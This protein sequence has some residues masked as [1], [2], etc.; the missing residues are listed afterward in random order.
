MSIKPIDYTSLIPKAQEVSRL[1]QIENNKP[2]N[3]IQHGNIQLQKEIEHNINK[4]RNTNKTEDFSIDPNK[5]DKD[6]G[7]KYY[8]EKEQEDTDK[9]EGQNKKEKSIIGSTIDIKI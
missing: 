9:K 8:Q 3:Q 6:K 4:V 5:E 7:K 1:K 2:N